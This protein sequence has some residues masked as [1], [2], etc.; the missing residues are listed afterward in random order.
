MRALSDTAAAPRARWDGVAAP[1][2]DAATVLVTR[3]A[4][5]GIEVL[6]MRRRPSLMFAAGMHVFPGGTVD[7]GDGADVPWIRPDRDTWAGRWRCEPALAGALVVAAVRETF[8]ETGILL[9]GADE[10]S[11]MG[12]VDGDEWRAARRRL[13]DGEL[14][15]GAFL[16]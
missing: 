6:L 9:A 3:P 2:R 7:D 1:P 14:T 12:A 10:S 15:L 16:R 4:G 11:V 8:E 13:E 5:A